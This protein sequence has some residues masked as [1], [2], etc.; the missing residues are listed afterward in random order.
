MIE[1][2]FAILCFMLTVFVVLDGWNIGAGIVHHLIARNDSERR[3]VIASLGPY[4]SWHEVWLVSFG[5][6]LFVAFP[7]A[8]ATTLPG[9]YLAIMML[10]WSLILRGM[11]VEIGGHLCD[12]LWR[13]FW[14]VV[15]TLSS[16]LLALLIGVGLGNL[17]RGV[18]LGTAGGDFW[19]PLFTNF[20][21]YGQVGLIDWY[22]L[23]TG[24]FTVAALGAHGAAYVALKTT[25]P[26][27]R[28]ATTWAKRL[29]L[30]TVIL[31]F[32]VTIGTAALRMELF[33]GML[34]NPF[35]WF[36]GGLVVVGGITL[37]RGLLNVHEQ[38]TFFG[39]CALIIA[40][41]MCGAAGSYPI[42]LHS[43][44]D[45][46]ASL[47]ASQA[48]INASLGTALLWWPLSLILAITYFM[49][50]MRVYAGKVQQPIEHYD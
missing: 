1:T 23:L 21:P 22:T 11:A 27:N 10:L 16:G 32:A 34:S 18:P 15:F 25:G 29:W 39:G 26:V 28:Q 41:F 17:I 48:A 43:T 3:L 7:V 35:C 49:L 30:L 19:M 20:S 36:G 42:M 13:S 4:W 24:A 5:G 37:L 31:L 45:P 2:W 46:A 9:F 6:V 38:Q 33:T 50:F 44:L 8:L 12:P 47:T 40:L 14:D